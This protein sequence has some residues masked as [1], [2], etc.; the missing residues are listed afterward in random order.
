MI[1]FSPVQE[2][3]STMECLE[4]IFT[5]AYQR[6]RDTNGVSSTHNTV[7]HISALLAW[8]LLLTICPMNEVKKK[9]EMWV[10]LLENKICNDCFYMQWSSVNKM[11]ILMKCDLLLR[12]LHKLP[13][14]LS[15]DDLNMRIAAGETLALLFEL[16]RETDAVSRLWQGKLFNLCCVAPWISTSGREFTGLCSLYWICP[17][18]S[19]C[20]NNSQQFSY[21]FLH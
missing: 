7:L 14:L 8:T 15:C 1:F 3:Y 2:L 11:Q 5:K 21:H 6:D 20:S 16:A 17:S 19:G 18:L 10:S 12:H 13:S 4:N 9:I